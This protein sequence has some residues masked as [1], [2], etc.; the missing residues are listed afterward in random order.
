MNK[1]K[2]NMELLRVVSIQKISLLVGLFL[3]SLLF[4][5]IFVSTILFMAG[6]PI[7]QLNLFL[8]VVLCSLVCWLFSKKQLKETLISI[9]IGLL[10]VILCVGINYFAYDWSWDG[11]TYHKS[12]TAL[13]ENG[14]NPLFETFYEYADKNFV[15]LS[16]VTQT[17]YDAYPKGTEIWAACIYR[18]FNFIEV[19]KSYNLIAAIGVFLIAYVLMLETKKLKKWQSALCSFLLVMNPV[20]FSQIFTYYNDG[21]MWQMVLLCTMACVW[22]TL[23]EQG[24]FE[25]LCYYLIFI[26]INLGFNTKFSSVIFFALP[27]ASMFVYWGVRTVK[28]GANREGK[29]LILKRF[30]VLALSVITGFGITGATSYVIN[31]LRHKNPFYTMI[32]PGSSDIMTGNLPLAYKNMPNIFRFICSLFSK[33]NSGKPEQIELKVPF[34]FDAEEFKAAQYYDIRV[35]GW[36][37]LFSGILIISLMILVMAYMD[38]KNKT[39]SDMAKLFSIIGITSILFIPGLWWA[40]YFAALFYLPV[41]AIVYLFAKSNQCVKRWNAHSISAIILGVLLLL[42]MTPN[43]ALCAETFREYEDIQNGLKKLQAISKHSNISVSCGS[44]YKF[45]GRMFSLYDLGINDFLYEEV[46]KDPTGKVFHARPLYYKVKDG[47][48]TA[49]NLIDFINQ[50]KEMEDT[51]LVIAARD[52]ASTALTEEI[53]FTMQD[54]GLEFDLPEKFRQ[55]YLAVLDEDQVLYEA[56]AEKELSYETEINQH[57]ISIISAGYNDGNRAS[58]KIDD[59]ELSLNKRGINIVAYDKEIGSVIDSISVDTYLDNTLSR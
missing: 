51:V 34:I 49:D 4:F 7:S 42:N 35:G 58:I 5:T 27:C 52:D 9:A 24:N 29:H 39:I 53:V 14:W 17:W 41:C 38:C 28:R 20:V 18:A 15:F 26:S 56:V 21:F 19:G 6:I 43:A 48:L 45:Y 1:R 2:S 54:L 16:D 22:I 8:A 12:I 31:M 50:A 25:S 47:V 44:P 57:K 32:G 13:L 30:F 55:S 10:I 59:R 11:N 46:V 40:R 33:A 23:F 3:L 36:G 37:I